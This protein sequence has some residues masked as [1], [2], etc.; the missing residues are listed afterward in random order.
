[1]L[2]VDQIKK[3]FAK[4][5]KKDSND[6][7][8]EILPNGMINYD[9][10]IT[11]DSY[12]SIVLPFN[13]ITGHFEMENIGVTNLELC[14]RECDMVWASGNALLSLKGHP[15]KLTG[16]HRHIQLDYIKDLP[17]LS[18][19]KIKDIESVAFV[20]Y[21]SSQEVE[22]ELSSIL[23]RYLPLGPKGMPSC[24]LAMKRAGYESNAKL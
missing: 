23:N 18:L 12:P 13:K 3:I 4:F 11:V 8:L 20:P 21:E 15:N 16:L 9:G 10:S 6:K 19:F 5:Y 14:P 24:M 17:L 22:Q 1:M 2:S 7:D